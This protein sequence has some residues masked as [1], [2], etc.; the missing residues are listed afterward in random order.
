MMK[1]SNFL[2][3]KL[4]DN[5]VLNQAFLTMEC[6]YLMMSLDTEMM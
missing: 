1:P 2:Q 4:I 5:Q 6:F 3:F